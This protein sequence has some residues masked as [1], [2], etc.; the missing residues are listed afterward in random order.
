MIPIVLYNDMMT[1]HFTL[2]RTGTE[3]ESPVERERK[4]RK[5]I[6]PKDIQCFLPF[7]KERS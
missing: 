6:F 3:A 7:G 4:T 1:N 2:P 5:T